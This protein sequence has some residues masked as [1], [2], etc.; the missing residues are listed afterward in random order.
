VQPLGYNFSAFIGGYAQY[1][2]MPLLVPEQCGFGGRYF[3]RAFDPSQILGDSCLETT[4]ELRYDVPQSIPQM[5]LIQLYGFSDYGNMFTRNA[6]VGTPTTVNAAS[7][8]T[9]VRL[10]WLT[11]LNT[12][13]QVAK[14]VEGP[15]DD[16][17]FFFAVNARY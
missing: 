7:V 15:R 11:Y 8:G 3:G 12:D 16:W 10:G 5:S 2:F 6:S 4:G 9:G 14:A 13:L 17:R 1:A